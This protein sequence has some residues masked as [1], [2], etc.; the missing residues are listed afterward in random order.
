M[1]RSSGIILFRRA[2]GKLMFLLL[3]YEA[4]HW[5]FPKG[6][7]ESGETEVE[8]AL[9]ETLE[10]TGIGDVRIKEGFAGRLDYF[11]RKQGKAVKKEVSYF[12]G[13]T[14]KEEVKISFEHVGFEWLHY[15]AALERLTYGNSREILKKAMMHLQAK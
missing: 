10:E 8:A 4:G 11:Y 1:E 6:H 13:E 5:D 9:R 14:E 15:E 2:S 3:H 7:V 12:L